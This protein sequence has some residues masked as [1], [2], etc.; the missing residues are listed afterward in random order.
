MT[1]KVRLGILGTGNMAHQ[2]AAGLQ[3]AEN[4]ELAAVGSRG[5]ETA[6]RFAQE[7]ALQR[8]Y[9]NY[10]DLATDPEVDLVYVSTPH[11][12]HVRNTLMCLEAGKAV[13]CEKPFAINAGE[14]RMMIAAAREKQ[15][16]L[17]EAM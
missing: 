9:S 12:C 13:I 7:F 3:H 4:V 8:R 1:E 10:E 17:M 5:R 11:S 16:F 14:A 2:F 15:L 6:E